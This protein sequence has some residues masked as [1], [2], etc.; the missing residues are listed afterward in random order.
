MSRAV[1]WRQMDSFSEMPICNV[2]AVAVIMLADFPGG[3]LS[4]ALIDC[5]NNAR[6]YAKRM[7]EEMRMPVMR[8]EYCGD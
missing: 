2:F 4:K 7:A 5:E 6:R 3:S 8:N 1:N